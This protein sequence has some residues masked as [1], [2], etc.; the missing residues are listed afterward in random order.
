MINF[1]EFT[2]PVNKRSEWQIPGPWTVDDIHSVEFYQHLAS[3]DFID[4][5][6][7]FGPTM[8]EKHDRYVRVIMAKKEDDNG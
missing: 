2:M 1:K 5:G 4:T 6:L 7:P 8:V 3:L